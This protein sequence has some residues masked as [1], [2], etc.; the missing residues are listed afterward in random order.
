MPNS[1]PLKG[2]VEIYTIIGVVEPR[3]RFAEMQCADLS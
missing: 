3:N 2:F 1:Q